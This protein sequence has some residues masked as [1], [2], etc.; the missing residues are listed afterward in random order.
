M[1]AAVNKGFLKVNRFALKYTINREIETLPLIRFRIGDRISLSTQ[2][3]WKFPDSKA[4]DTGCGEVHG[5]DESLLALAA[6]LNIIR[7][8]RSPLD[9]LG[10]RSRFR[11]FAILERWKR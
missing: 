10:F 8:R 7:T 5:R 3:E 11:L 6:T 2:T 9:L 1:I 4:D